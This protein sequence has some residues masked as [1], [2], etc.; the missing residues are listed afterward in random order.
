[1][2][3]S[4]QLHNITFRPHWQEIKLGWGA[5][6]LHFSVPMEPLFELTMTSTWVAMLIQPDLGILN[7]PSLSHPSVFFLSAIS[8]NNREKL[9]FSINRSLPLWSVRVWNKAGLC[10]YSHHGPPITLCGRFSH[11]QR[12]F[13]LFLSGLKC[14]NPKEMEA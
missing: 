11:L 3:I 14:S 2:K 7:E 4:S 13:F 5:P 9:R 12:L 6:S 1:M 8:N 10:G